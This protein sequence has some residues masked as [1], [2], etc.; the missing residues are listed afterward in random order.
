MLWWKSKAI[1]STSLDP[2]F[3]GVL[4]TPASIPVLMTFELLFDGQQVHV[5]PCTLLVKFL[6]SEADKAILKAALSS[7]FSLSL[8]QVQLDLDAEFPVTTFFLTNK[9][10]PKPLLIR[11]RV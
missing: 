9:N 1:N 2:V 4:V 5:L 7:S 8:S 10:A 11:E 3:E 6:N